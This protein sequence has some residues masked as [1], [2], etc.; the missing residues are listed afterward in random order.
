MKTQTTPRKILTYVITILLTLA[1]IILSLA[2]CSA[3]ND[4]TTTVAENESTRIAIGS[5]ENK[6]LL[7]KVDYTTSTFE[8][9]AELVLEGPATNNFTIDTRYK[10]PGDFGSI[11]LFYKEREQKIFDGGIIWMGLGVISYPSNFLPANRFE[12]TRTTDYVLP[13]GGFENVFNPNNE[14]YD[15]QRI[16]N[17]I[18]NLIKV[19]EYLSSNPDATVKIFLYTPSVGIGNPQEWDWIIILKN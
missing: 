13:A 5:Q 16:W 18:Q 19:R 11:Q 3:G 17:S 12:I 8:E 4:Q 15:Y 10:A 1:I 6:V 14:R 2:S 7:L 9:G